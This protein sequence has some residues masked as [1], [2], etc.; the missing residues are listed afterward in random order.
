MEHSTL[1]IVPKQPLQSNGQ[2]LVNYLFIYSNEKINDLL[3]IVWVSILV[4]PKLFS[5]VRCLG[6]KVLPCRHFGEH[7]FELWTLM[8]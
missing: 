8:L 5:K 3:T 7:N 6:K 2:D 4:Q 1:L